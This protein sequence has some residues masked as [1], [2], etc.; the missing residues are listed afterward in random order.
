[1]SR[2]S[3]PRLEFGALLILLVTISATIHQINAGKCRKLSLNYYFTSIIMSSWCNFEEA[4]AVPSLYAYRKKNERKK[5]RSMR[6]RLVTLFM[7]VYLNV[8]VTF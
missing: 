5:E 8:K 1:M 6:K 7:C 2:H 4:P 3:S